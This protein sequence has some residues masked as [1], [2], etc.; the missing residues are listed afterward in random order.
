MASVQFER[1]YTR[2]DFD[3]LI[4]WLAVSFNLDPVVWN[5]FNLLRIAHEICVYNVCSLYYRCDHV[6]LFIYHITLITPFVRLLARSVVWFSLFVI[7]LLLTSNIFNIY[8]TDIIIHFTFRFI[9]ASLRMSRLVLKRYEIYTENLSTGVDT[10]L[11][12]FTHAK[13]ERKNEGNRERTP[14]VKSPFWCNEL[15]FLLKNQ[16]TNLLDC[17]ASVLLFNIQKLGFNI[18]YNVGWKMSENAQEILMPKIVWILG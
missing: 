10:I 1:K 14:N 12:I 2:I 8:S 7:H 16:K 9:S 4:C 6:L 3:L 18:R 13:N 11:W 15:R 17:V 5:S